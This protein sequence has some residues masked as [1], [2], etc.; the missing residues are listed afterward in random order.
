[1]VEEGKK[2]SPTEQSGGRTSDLDG[3]RTHIFG[4]G[5]RYSIQL[6]YEANCPAGKRMSK[7]TAIPRR[8]SSRKPSGRKMPVYSYHTT[9]SSK[10][11]RSNA[12]TVASGVG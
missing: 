2:Q 3:I 9:I 12:G 6:N 7:C 11:L 5:G 10:G 1:M 4:S 8:K